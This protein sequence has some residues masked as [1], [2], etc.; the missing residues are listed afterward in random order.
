MLQ[1]R[2]AAAN[3]RDIQASLDAAADRHAA[4]FAAL[5]ESNATREARLLAEISDANATAEAAGRK[6]S[7]VAIAAAAAAE[8]AEE[9]RRGEAAATAAALGALRAE[10]CRLEARLQ[11][12][13][14][15]RKRNATVFLLFLGLKYSASK[16][17]LL[18]VVNCQSFPTLGE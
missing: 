11:Q 1:L 3:A 6:A 9:H 17:Y 4:D 14:C 2:E 8:A 15:P 13:F 7:S 12:V 10:V 16:W 5:R 18:F